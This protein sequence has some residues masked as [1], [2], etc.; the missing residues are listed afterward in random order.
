MDFGKVGDLLVPVAAQFSSLKT[1]VGSVQRL[2][3][4]FEGPWIEDTL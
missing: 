1:E 3:L 4:V 2:L